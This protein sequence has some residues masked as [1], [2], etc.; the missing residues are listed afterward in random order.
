MELFFSLCLC[1]KCDSFK[2][3]MVNES[4]TWYAAPFANTIIYHGFQSV[5]VEPNWSHHTF[6]E[7]SI[8]FLSVALLHMYSILHIF[9]FSVY[10]YSFIYFFYVSVSCCI[11]IWCCNDFVCQWRL[12]KFSIFFFF[13]STNDNVI[14]AVQLI[15]CLFKIKVWPSY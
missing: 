2:S 9:L 8:Y 5:D 10:I 6:L 3:L 13:K 4:N 15:L 1:G 14:L 11:M 7:L 12:L